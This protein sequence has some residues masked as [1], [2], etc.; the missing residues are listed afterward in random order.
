[1]AFENEPLISINA[2]LLTAAQSMTIRVALESFALDLNV[3][4]LGPGE[5]SRAMV[6][7]YLACISEIRALMFIPKAPSPPEADHG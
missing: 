1:M 7:G 2:H 3:E 6:A 4:G 5:H